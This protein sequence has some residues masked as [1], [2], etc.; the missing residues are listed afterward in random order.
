ML[1]GTSDPL[2][3][4]DGIPLQIQLFGGVR[5]TNT[6]GQNLDVGPSKCQAVL[7]V[8]ALQAG[9][10]VPV[11]KIIELVWGEHPPRTADKTLQSYVTRLRKGLGAASISRVGAAYQLEVPTAAT[12]IGRF[13]IALSSGE[14][15]QALAEWAGTPMAGLDA[16]GL[17]AAIDG[18]TEQWL[19]A[20][21]VE[22]E[23][24]IEEHAVGVIGPLTELTA[25]HPFRE[26]LWALLM[27]ALYRVGRQAEALAAYRTARTHLVEELGVEPGPRLRELEAQILGQDAELS[28][29]R[30]ASDNAQASHPT[31][32]VTFG[33]CEVVGASALWSDYR[34]HMVTAMA[35]HDEIVLA[36]TEASQGHIFSSGGDS[37]CVAF[38]RAS[39]ARTWAS[40]IQLRVSEESWPQ[41]LTIRISVGLHTGEPE[42]RRSRYFGPSVNLTK[43]LVSAANG[44]QTIL[45]N[46]TA[47]LLGTTDMLDLGTYRLGDSSA[48]QSVFQLGDIDHPPLRIQDERRGNLPLR[49]SRLF[50]RSDDLDA[51][52]QALK[53]SAV[54][55]L[56]G[57]GGIG[58]TRLALAAGHRDATNR[59]GGVWFVELA[60]VGQSDD[61]VR[62][63]ASVLSIKENPER[64]LIESVI[65]TLQR[66]HILLV[67]DNCEHVIDGAAALA[68]Q[69]ADACSNVKILAT[70]REG[71]GIN[72]ER[73][74]AV[75]PL[76]PTGPAVELFN[77]RALAASSAFDPDSSRS[78]VEEICRRLDGVPLAIE[79]AAAR[80]RSLEPAE[81]V[82]RLSDRLRLLTGGRR[83][84]VERHRT[85]RATIQWS[86]DL[87]SNE[88]QRLFQRLSIF[89]GPFT[90]RAVEEIASE[91]SCFFRNFDIDELLGSLVD[92]SMV[93]A[94][95]GPFGRRFRLLETMRQFGAEH[96]TEVQQSDQLGARHAQWCLSEV[97]DADKL[98]AGQDEIQGVGRLQELW[99][100]LRAAF[101]WACAQGDDELAFKLLQP[102]GPEISL[103]SQ[104]QVWD[105]VER[106]LE[107]TKPGN[108]EVLLFGLQ[109]TA[110]R[111]MLTHDSEGFEQVASRY[112]ALDHPMID[113]ARAVAHDEDETLLELGP[114]A[115]AYLRERGQL[116]AAELAEI[117][118]VVGPYL[119]CGRFEEFDALISKKAEQYEAEG[120]PTLLHWVL[121][122]QGYSASFQGHAERASEFFR[123]A[124]AVDIPERSVSLSK[125]V[126]ARIA[127]ESGQTR[128]AFVLLRAYLEEL[129][130][131]DNLMI[132]TLA[133]NEYV[134]MMCSIGEFPKAARILGH[135][136]SNTNF[137]RTVST[138]FGPVAQKMLV[139]D[140][141]DEA[142][143]QR[144][145][146]RDM[147]ALAAIVHM[148]DVLQ[149]LIADL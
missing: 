122:M 40:R 134:A 95:S 106:L 136:E 48:D 10:A 32:T 93:I 56:V 49:T 114:P 112:E 14:T 102:V 147:D 26:G 142:V 39:S 78:D 68:V 1:V 17:V 4:N 127:L 20:V 12:D 82:E 18:L 118:S 11:T 58:K 53:T 117:S 120:P 140:P 66:R 100:N 28:A 94:E 47:A 60:G 3:R 44:G 104:S 86:Y 143:K 124:I 132:G 110:H 125:P 92:R 145:D 130:E 75:S 97:Q 148:S 22:T 30:S 83:A 108:H 80:I 43:A 74:I 116:R 52:A 42:E 103:R 34:Q 8:L 141:T 62:T 70:S 13:R 126:E 85:L 119:A 123:R 138:T 71:L 64:T 25:A 16:P 79:L 69:I 35:R 50:G 128:H 51:I 89:A 54:V 7:A 137:S 113:Y 29:N 84:T 67:L 33:F 36:A 144:K 72:P 59:Q 31:G 99:P 45:S 65:L 98:L 15:T 73:L 105:W 90:L 21:E 87:L 135:L 57:P 96:L 109:W 133:S 24:H 146:G 139:D 38:D 101:E 63:V 107:I 27:T 23:L 41:D 131:T 37:F 55:T 88:E 115:V 46:V 111:Y 76:A 2:A 9:H 129:I 19:G 61:V 149:E 6:D 81:L 77:D 5:A 121:F 91:P